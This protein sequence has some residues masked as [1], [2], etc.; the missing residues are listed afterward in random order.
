MK[1][2]TLLFVILTAYTVS[3]QNVGI[4]TINPLA[5][6]HITDSSVLFS[7]TGDIPA[8]QGNPPVSGE[9]RRMMWYPDKAA[10]RAGYVSGTNWDNNLIGNYSF[11]AGYDTWASGENSTSLGRQT[12]ASG[13]YSTSMGN[14]TIA[15]GFSSTVLGLYND[16]ILTTNETSVS[17]TTPFLIVGNGDNTTTR[18]NALVVLKNGNT[19]IGDRKSVV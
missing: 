1:K 4:G 6:L 18:R 7:A 3:A 19:G 10:F 8:V 17:S 2:L 16:S 14:Q 11:A 12:T 5:R 15:K 9:G 13:N